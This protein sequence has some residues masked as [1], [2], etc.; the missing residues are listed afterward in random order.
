MMVVF[1]G[2]T[3]VH[4]SVSADSGAGSTARECEL[5]DLHIL[6]LETMLWIQPEVTALLEQ[7]AELCMFMTAT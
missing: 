2:V 4:T 6:D 7:I 5:N 3:T 1:G